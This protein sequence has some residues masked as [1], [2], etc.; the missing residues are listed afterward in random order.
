MGP[1]LSRMRVKRFVELR[2]KLKQYLRAY[3]LLKGAR[4]YVDQHLLD[5]DGGRTEAFSTLSRL[6]ERLEQDT[7]PRLTEYDALTA[8]LNEEP[9]MAQE[10]HTESTARGNV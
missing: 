10:N 4:A 8:M 2:R 1:Y 9:R 6:M 7:E 3:T 5:T